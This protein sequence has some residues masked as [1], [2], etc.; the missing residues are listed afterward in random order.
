MIYMLWQT[1]RFTNQEIAKLF[2]LTYSSVSR[3]VGFVRKQLREDKVVK[4]KLDRVSVL[5]K[6]WYHILRLVVR[7]LESTGWRINGRMM[8]TT[9]LIYTRYRWLGTLGWGLLWPDYL[10][11][12]SPL[13]LHRGFH[14]HGVDRRGR[15][16]ITHFWHQDD[17]AITAS[18]VGQFILFYPSLLM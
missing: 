15:G 2:G 4:H 14:S 7:L 8:T 6:M 5:I 16:H 13:W 1:G 10:C 12:L 18:S 3:R 11:G 9:G 17:R